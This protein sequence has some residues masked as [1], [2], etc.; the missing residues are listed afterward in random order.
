MRLITFHHYG[1]LLSLVPS[2][3]GMSEPCH[4][5]TCSTPSLFGFPLDM[6]YRIFVNVKGVYDTVDDCESESV[7]LCFSWANKMVV[8][9]EWA[10]EVVE[11]VLSQTL[12]VII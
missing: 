1:A 9:F 12:V 7:T 10:S 5:C 8:S 3:A 2:F 11:N 4:Q 6:F